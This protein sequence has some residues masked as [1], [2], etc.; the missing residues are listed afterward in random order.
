MKKSDTS[1]QTDIGISPDP[2]F[3]MTTGYWVSKTLMSA[4][5]LEVFTKLSGSQSVTLEQ[6]QNNI[7]EMD[8]RPAEVFVTALISLGLLNV[9]TIDGNVTKKENR[10][11]NSQM[12][13]V[14]LDKNK[15]TYIGDFVTMLDTQLYYRWG[16]LTQALKTNKPVKDNSDSSNDTVSTNLSAANILEQAK[17]NQPVE[18]IQ[19]FTRAMYGVSV[20]PAME[21]GKVFDFSNY[22]KMMDI[23]GGSGIYSIEVVKASP[24][25][26]AIMLDLGPVCEVADEYV[27]QF[28]L[29]DRIQT[30]VLDFLKEDLPKDCDV[31]LLS[32][33][34]H[35]LSMENDKMLLRKIYDSLPDE[36]GV[37]LISEWLLNDEKTGPIPPALTGL[38]M[39][40]DMPEGRNYS[41]AEVS[42]MLTDVGFTNIEKRPLAGPAEVVI[43]YKHMK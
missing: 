3:Q 23:G 35:F 5:E 22:K 7:L 28:N 37:I 25:M 43:G 6:L 20:I 4:V 30:Q 16:K 11:S 8:T 32:H 40:V 41:Y 26:S 27:K 21:L 10:Y 2:I 12:S 36:N 15:P 14:F 1:T 38:A 19:T 17:K 9:I 39:I 13:E 29:Q 18:Q 31:V 42:E 24:N 34:V 33:I